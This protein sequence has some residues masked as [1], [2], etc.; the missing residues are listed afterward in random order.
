MG[1]LRR[2]FWVACLSLAAVDASAQALASSAGPEVT[3]GAPATVEVWNRPILTLRA[4]VGQQDPEQRADKVRGRIE[5][6]PYEDLS[7]L[8]RADP[9]SVGSLHGWM[10]FVGNQMV[11][12]ILPQD[13]DLESGRSLEQVSQEAVERLRGVLQARAEQQRLPRLLRGVAFAVG[14]TLVYA[15]T[16]WAVM[17]VK[18]RFQRGLASAARRSRFRVFG[19]QVR[20]LLITLERYAI[21]VTAFGVAL[22]GGYLWLTFTLVQFPY[23]QPW[24][25]GLGRYLRDLLA[26]LGERALDAVPGLFT[27]LII[28]LLTR[29]VVHS[30][31]AFFNA[32]EQG[33]LET[34][35]IEPGTVGATR[36]LV[37]AVIWIFAIT[38]AYPYIP[39]SDTAAFKGVSVFVGLMVSLG[40]A[41]FINQIMSGLVIVYSRAFGVGDYVRV[42]ETEGLVSQVGLL[43]TKVVTRKQEEVTIPNAVVVGHKLTNYSERAE[44]KGAIAST[45]VTIGYDTPWRQVHGL[46]TLAASRTPGVRKEPPPVVLQRALSDFYV[47]YELLVR[48]E[49]L[50]DRIRVLSDLHGQVLDAFNEYGVQ[51]MSPHFEDQPEKPVVVD[52]PQWHAPPAVE[53]VRR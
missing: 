11:A 44:N 12:A 20:P 39:G 18:A 33:R 37:V 36:R 14:A 23:T 34:S 10:I 31:N 49:R 53:P 4:T 46:L 9:A 13:L 29:L 35:W 30:T 40:S 27:V 47:E 6:L 32:V 5:A 24:G 50:E 45:T 51:I 8:V 15:L 26:T 43:S 19:V 52:R 25:R 1:I 42:G 22:V 48:L 17:R 7:D 38:V 41:G 2:Y 21:K 28:F 3:V 16:L